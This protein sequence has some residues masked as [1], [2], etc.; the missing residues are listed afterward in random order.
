METIEKNISSSKGS[1][2]NKFSSLLF[3]SVFISLQSY[4]I[5]PVSG[6]NGISA[7]QAD[8]V[9]TEAIAKL[10]K[11]HGISYSFIKLFFQLNKSI[12][13][14]DNHKEEWIQQQL[15]YSLKVNETLFSLESLPA[16]LPLYLKF[17]ISHLDQ[18]EYHVK[19]LS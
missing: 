8:S 11:K 16:P 3:L 4:L 13:Y 1:T 10:N 17:N 5:I 2:R 19:L 14:S 15:N 18:D 9:R 12:A 7:C 6:Q